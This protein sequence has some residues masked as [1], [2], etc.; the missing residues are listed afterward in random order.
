MKAHIL[1]AL[2]S[3]SSV[4]GELPAKKRVRRACLLCRSQKL[5]CSGELPKCERC[6]SKRLS[7]NYQTEAASISASGSRHNRANSRRVREEHIRAP[8]AAGSLDQT[9][10]PADSLIGNAERSSIHLSQSV[11]ASKGIIQQHIDAFFQYVYPTSTFNFIHRGSFLRSWHK[12]LM[13]PS[14]LRASV[15]IARRYMGLDQE[16]AARWL[17]E[18][19]R[20]VL[21]DL[22]L[23]SIPKLQ[24]LLFLIFDRSASAN[25]SAVWYLLSLAARIAHGLKL[26]QPTDAV[27][28]TN[29]ECR[30]RLVWCI[31]SNERMAGMETCPDTTYPPLCPRSFV[32]VQLPCDERSFEL[33]FECKTHSLDDLA[34]N[35]YDNA[36]RLGATAYLIRILDLREQIQAF[37]HR[38][39]KQPGHWA[40]DDEF[41][42]LEQ[43]L[44]EFS[45]SLPAEMQDSERAVYIRSS[46]P[47]SSVYIMVQTW[48][49]TC[50]AEL[51]GPVVY[52]SPDAGDSPVIQSQADFA[53]SC[54]SVLLEHTMSL[55]H[56]WSRIWATQQLSRKLFVTDWNIAPCVYGNTRDV[57]HIYSAQPSLSA[58]SRATIEAALRLNL[59][60]LGTQK[61]LSEYSLRWVSVR[62][63]R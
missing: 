31:Y 52:E 58:E 16:P 23:I 25:F 47:E 22:N 8:E 12:G 35:R 13:S 20:D 42:R 39:G 60:I 33:E 18:S 41:W 26:G 61:G 9:V 51:T 11:D 36:P 5:R 53:D 28:F 21:T 46:T 14:L 44:S 17:E 59:D 7:C 40:G 3:P 30:R 34:Q 37:S 29:Q 49:R 45:S 2:D 1:D 43:E 19:E 57:V 63:Q 55:H 50:W 4:D 54:R 38:H 56:F 62:I 48:L 32:Q 24:I 15:G 10:E 6:L 27:P